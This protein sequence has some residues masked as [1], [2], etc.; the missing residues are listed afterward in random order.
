MT[1]FETENGAQTKTTLTYC[2]Y[3][4]KNDI[5]IIVHYLQDR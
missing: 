1:K 3:L 2:I 4:K 5:I